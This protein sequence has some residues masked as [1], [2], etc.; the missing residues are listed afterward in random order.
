M[1]LVTGSVTAKP[2]TIAE[3]T[4]VAREHVHRSR[5]EPGCISHHVSVDADDPL[6]LHFIERWEDAAKLKA[7]FAVRESRALW[8]TLQDLAAD[9]GGMHIYEANGVHI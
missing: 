2:D 4:R 3:M 5:T 8:K 1:I 9:A 6:M 7:H